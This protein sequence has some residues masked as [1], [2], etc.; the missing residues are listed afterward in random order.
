MK[1]SKEYLVAEHRRPFGGLRNFYSV[2]KLRKTSISFGN[3][4]SLEGISGLCQKEGMLGSFS[5]HR[6]T[7]LNLTGCEFHSF[8]YSGKDSTTLELLVR[9]VVLFYSGH[10]LR[11]NST[12]VNFRT[13]FHSI[14]N[15]TT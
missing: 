12:D 14:I 9:L 8:L 11:L 13:T 4:R 5:V 15:S 2:W 6:E 3:Y 10:T 1:G 7:D